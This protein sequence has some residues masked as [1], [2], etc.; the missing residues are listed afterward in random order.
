MGR[1]EEFLGKWYG[2][3][4]TP[5][6]L[7]WLTLTTG[8]AFIAFI[9][10]FLFTT[11][12][13]IP[14]F[15]I[16]PITGFL[17]GLDLFLLFKHIHAKRTDDEG[18]QDDN[19]ADVNPTASRPFPVPLPATMIQ[20]SYQ[21]LNTLPVQNFSKHE[22]TLPPTYEEA[23]GRPVPSLPYG[24]APSLRTNVYSPSAPSL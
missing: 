12:E 3:A 7:T 18:V 1:E 8:V 19:I 4:L 10:C 9:A 2:L 20:S 11:S 6:L 13:S 21:D 24:L 17:L 15:V 5:K 14:C 23:T 22:S 16:L